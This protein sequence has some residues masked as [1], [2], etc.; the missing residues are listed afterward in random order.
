MAVDLGAISSFYG[1]KSRSRQTISYVQLMLS[2]MRIL[3]EE[4]LRCIPRGRW[5]VRTRLRHFS[6]ISYAVPV[7]RLVAWI[8][9]D[10]FEIETF[11]QGGKIFALLSVVPFKDED[12]HFPNFF[13]A[14]KFQFPQTNHRVYVRHR[15]TNRRAAWFFG[16]SL[17]SP[18]VAIPKRL[19]GMPWHKASYDVQCVYDLEERRYRSYNFKISSPWCD[20]S[21]ELKDTGEPLTLLDGFRDFDEMKLV[22]THP[23]DG[24]Y[25]RSDGIVGQYNIWHEEMSFTLAKPK[26][27]YF[28]LYERLGIM[29]RSEMQNPH[30]AIICPQAAFSIQLPPRALK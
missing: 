23:T 19:W 29:S 20:G 13:P 17:G 9:Q 15:A 14:A 7:E 21:I 1:K 26:N 8:P 28:S 18:L 6:I 27:L 2:P 11:T 12:F 3:L 22:L 4:N 25:F 16:T 24:Y 30:S 5:V 10:S